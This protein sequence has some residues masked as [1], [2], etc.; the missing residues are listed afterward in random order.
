MLDKNSTL[1]NIWAKA[2]RNGV[3]KIEDVPNLLNLREVVASILK[4]G[5]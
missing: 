5:E 2:V 1:A 4:G 3:K